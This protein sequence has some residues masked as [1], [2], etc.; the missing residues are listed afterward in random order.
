MAIK[1]LRRPPHPVTLTEGALTLYEVELSATPT[2][3][4]ARPARRRL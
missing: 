2:G 1:R 4:L 3:S